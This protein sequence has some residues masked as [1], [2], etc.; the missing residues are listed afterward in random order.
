MR[1]KT[2]QRV[3]LALCVAAFHSLSVTLSKNYLNS[4]LLTVCLNQQ[5][6]KQF[7]NR[8]AKDKIKIKLAFKCATS[9]CL[10]MTFNMFCTNKLK[11]SKV[12]GETYLIYYT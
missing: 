12:G 3:L 4:P 11:S 7:F 8:V 1:P 6:K 5:T 2:R 9:S 10:K